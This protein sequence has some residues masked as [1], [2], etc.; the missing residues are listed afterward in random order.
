MSRNFA[1]LAMLFF[2][3]NCVKDTENE[4]QFIRLDEFSDFSGK[5]SELFSLVD[6]VEIDTTVVFETIDKAIIFDGGIV[7]LHRF[8]QN[9]GVYHYDKSGNFIKKVGY[10]GEGPGGFNTPY[11]VIITQKGFEILDVNKLHQYDSDGTYL[12]SKNI[13]FPA[14]RFNRKD[15]HYFFFC[16]DKAGTLTVTNDNLEVLGRFVNNNASHATNPHNGLQISAQ[17]VFG[18][19]N[20]HNTIYKYNGKEFVIAYRMVNGVN[21][22][23]QEAID[24]TGDLERLAL[25]Y[26]DKFL[27]KEIFI[28]LANHQYFVVRKG[29][30]DFVALRNKQ[31]KKGILINPLNVE[32]DLTNEAYFPF[33]IGSSNDQL[34]SYRQNELMDQGHLFTLYMYEVLKGN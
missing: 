21:P 15:N 13:D 17:G 2:C 3:T 19:M 20:Y 32:N 24:Q 8:F 18:F 34:I 33:I 1:L 4:N 7:I 6:S 12:T 14:I 30:Q 10:F 22:I 5:V 27:F 26:A 11:D 16:T 25:K 28:D 9:K 23:S 29:K 31:T